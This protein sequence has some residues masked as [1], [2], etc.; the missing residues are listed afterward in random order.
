MDS[1]HNKIFVAPYRQPPVTTETVKVIKSVG[2]DNLIH[3]LIVLAGLA[4][5]VCTEITGCR[6]GWFAR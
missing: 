6:G 3:L 1:G 2:T 4:S 5:L